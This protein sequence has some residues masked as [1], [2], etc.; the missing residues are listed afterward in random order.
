MICIRW[1][2]FMCCA[3][4]QSNLYSSIEGFAPINYQFIGGNIY[5]LIGDFGRGSWALATCL[6][7]RCDNS[8]EGQI[9]LND[10]E[11]C[12]TELI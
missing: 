5:G 6:G 9:C 10:K 2:E 4:C 8:S 12:C 11:I 3:H 1:N 7:G